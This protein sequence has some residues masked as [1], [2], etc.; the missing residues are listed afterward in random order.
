MAVYACQDC[1]RSPRCVAVM[2]RATLVPVPTALLVMTAVMLYK[3]LALT[4]HAAV[5]VLCHLMHL[6]IGAI[7]PLPVTSNV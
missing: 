5:S 6:A 7:L 4:S 3:F 2:D 1:V